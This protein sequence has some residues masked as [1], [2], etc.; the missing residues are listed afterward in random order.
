MA[1]CRIIVKDKEVRL[2]SKE[3][4]LFALLVQNVNRIVIY[5]VLLEKM[6]GGEYTDDL[7]YVRIYI[8]HLRRLI[9]MEPTHPRYI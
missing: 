1:E 4:K 2:T 3:F 5:K 7:D 6:W 8:W 9:E